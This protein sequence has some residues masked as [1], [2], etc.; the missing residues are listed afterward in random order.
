MSVIVSI[1]VFTL[2]SSQSSW[3]YFLYV[4]RV[5]W[6]RSCVGILASGASLYMGASWIYPGI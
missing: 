5:V 3:K 1:S 4:F 6:E 2:M